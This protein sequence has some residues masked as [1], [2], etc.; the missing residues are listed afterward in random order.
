MSHSAL[1]SVGARKF[2]DAGSLLTYAFTY[3]TNPPAAETIP[4]GLRVP[5]PLLRYGL[6]PCAY[7]LLRLYLSLLRVN[8]VGE[9]AGMRHLAEHG[10]LIAALWHQRFL[11]A[12]AY[13]TKFRKFKLCVMI[14]QSR[15]GDLIAPIAKR[16]G[17]EP[18][19]GSSS[20]GGKKAL[21]AIL[22]TLEERPGV[23]HIVDG[24]RGPKGEVKPGLIGMAQVTGAAIIPIFVSAHRAWVMG[25]WDRFL[26]PK[27]FSRV[28]IRWGQPV[29]VPRTSDPESFEKYRKDVETTLAEGYAKD[30]LSWG[31]ERPL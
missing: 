7:Y 9:E 26:V 4:L 14:S 6:L 19:R 23:V 17:L 27:P 13:V 18:V 11:P 5:K 28:K 22:K 20:R 24:P 8:V 31:W 15:D 25:S 21:A 16:L 1:S 29:V 30:D 3:A 10:R 12:L 2:L